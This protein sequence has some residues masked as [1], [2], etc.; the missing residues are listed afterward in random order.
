MD[1]ITTVWGM[2]VGTNEDNGIIPP[3]HGPSIE[4][5]LVIG[6]VKACERPMSNASRE[7]LEMIPG[8]GSVR[9]SAWRITRPVAIHVR[10]LETVDF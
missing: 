6:T 8:G 9:H 7:L 10:V 4:G 5:G 1:L 2:V 3:N